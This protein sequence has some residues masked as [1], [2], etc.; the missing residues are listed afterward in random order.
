MRA[1]RVLVVGLVA[2]IVVLGLALITAIIGR[3]W[4]S[5]T[6]FLHQRR[7]SLKMRPISLTLRGLRHRTH[8]H[9]LIY[10]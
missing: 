5:M 2:V 8:T 9:G 10:A 4:L 1:T 6:P 3:S 7:S